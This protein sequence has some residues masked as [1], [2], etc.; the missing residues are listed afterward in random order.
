MIDIEEFWKAVL[1]QDA[2]SMRGFFKDTAYVNWHC[3]NEHFTVDEYIKAN[4]EYPGKWDG[5]IERKEIIG[6]TLVVVVNVY[7]LDKEL[8][9][10]V[11]SFMQ[12][13]D[14]K[15]IAMDEYWGDDGSAP[16]WRLDKHI[17]KAIR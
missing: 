4:C 3:T 12:I 15:I 2:A 7:T 5:N 8:S 1:T 6:N 16:Q 13:E 11:V 9:F 17:G 10:H 14:N